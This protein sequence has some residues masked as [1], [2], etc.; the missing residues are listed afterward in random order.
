MK[1]ISL[2]FHVSTDS[3][4]DNYTKKN[5]TLNDKFTVIKIA[6]FPLGIA[7]GIVAENFSFGFV[8]TLL[9]PGIAHCIQAMILER[10]FRKEKDIP[11]EKTIGDYIKSQLKT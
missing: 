3:L 10:K 7:L 1:N 8:M 2:I 4:L 5:I 9:L 11:S 6:L